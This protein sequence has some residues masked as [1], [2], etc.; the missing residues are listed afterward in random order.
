[1]KLLK[2]YIRKNLASRHMGSQMVGALAL[3]AVRSFLGIPTLEWYVRFNVFFLKTDDQA[4]KIQIF[5][6]TKQILEEVNLALEKVGYKT[7][8]VEIRI[9]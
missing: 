7:R 9:K 2:E 6:Q 3:N 4:L 5:R 1:M 8:I